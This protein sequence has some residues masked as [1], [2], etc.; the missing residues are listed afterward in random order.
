MIFEE[1]ILISSASLLRTLLESM[2]SAIFLVNEDIKIVEINNAFKTLFHKQLAEIEHLTCGEAI[3]CQFEILEQQGCGK[4]SHCETCQIK[5]CIEEAFKLKKSNSDEIIRRHFQV[6]GKMIKKHLKMK[7]RPIE[8][9]EKPLTL[10]VFEDVSLSE[11]QKCEL[12]KQNERMKKEL[13][14]AKKVQQDILP[15]EFQE[16]ETLDFYAIYDPMEE[17]GGDFYD[18]LPLNDELTGIFIS[19]IAGHGLHAAMITTMIKVLLETS[20]NVLYNPALLMG[21]LN[22]KLLNLNQETFLTALYGVYDKNKK[23]FTYCQAGHPYPFLIRDRK[24]QKL[25]T[26]RNLILGV[27]EDATFE[28]QTLQLKSKDKIFL[29]TDGLNE[30]LNSFDTPFEK[31]I[32]KILAKNAD[33]DIKTILQIM[34]SEA[35]LFRSYHKFEDDICLLGCE[36]KE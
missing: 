28:N 17:L 2:P 31:R 7:T 8:F 9:E 29:Y 22:R 20:K 12:L 10:V 33:K 36:I 23:T 4:N 35:E 21:F 14:L 11:E 3:G 26:N 34:Y 16:F 19:D 5:A 25:N 15:E 27:F 30:N 6:S 18:I 24:V 32:P 13:D 1:K